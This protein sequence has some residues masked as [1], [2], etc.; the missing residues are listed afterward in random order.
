[1]ERV[2]S[3]IYG[4][5][6]V[7]AAQWEHTKERLAGIAGVRF[8]ETASYTFPSDRRAGRGRRRQGAFGIPSLNLFGSR[9]APGAPP[10]EGTSISRR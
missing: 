1:L 10:R 5:S 3:S 2:R 9:N 7:I 8:R 6:K 4:P